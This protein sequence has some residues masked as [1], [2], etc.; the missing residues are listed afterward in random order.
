[1]DEDGLLASGA[2]GEALTWMDARVNGRAIT[3]RRGKP[4]EIQALWFNALSTMSDFAMGI[5]RGD[6]SK[7]YRGAAE[8][9]Q[10]SFLA[11]F[12]EPG[13]G[14]ADVVDG[15]A[16]DASIRPNQIFAVSLHHSM[17]SRP[18]AR[19][20]FELKKQRHQL[21]GQFVEVNCATLRGDAAMSALFGH[22]KGS[23]TGATAD[24]VRANQTCAASLPNAW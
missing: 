19:R 16:R 22:V 15:S 12:P 2:D 14:L 4:V 1:M 10:R 20:I 6:S 8:K 23:F 21:A 9:C 5:G 13:A 18:L 11:K 24:R 7:V 3:P 17:V